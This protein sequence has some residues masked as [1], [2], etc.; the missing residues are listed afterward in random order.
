[1]ARGQN[2]KTKQ[3][4]LGAAIHAAFDEFEPIILPFTLS[5]GVRVGES[6]DDGG[7]V[8]A[9]TADKGDEFGDLGCLSA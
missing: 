7:I 3:V 8:T 5:V 9:Q 4:K 2:T 6:S 1:M